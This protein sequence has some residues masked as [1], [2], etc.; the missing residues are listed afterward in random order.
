MITAIYLAFGNLYMKHYLNNFSVKYTFFLDD[1]S[2][3]VKRVTF[4][5]RVLQTECIQSSK[6]YSISCA[7][8]KGMELVLNISNEI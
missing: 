2:T 7:I 5:N 8:L 3:S 4:F 1:K 6:T